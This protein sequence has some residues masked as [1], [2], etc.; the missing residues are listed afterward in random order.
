MI[1]AQAKYKN[2]SVDLYWDETNDQTFL[3]G[4]EYMK[5]W[6]TSESIEPWTWPPDFTP[7]VMMPPDKV[8]RQVY[9]LEL[10]GSLEVEWFSLHP[11]IIAPVNVQI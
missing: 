9:K 2:A 5:E 10:M 3:Y 7:S 8:F 6:I 11:A 4:D 1:Y